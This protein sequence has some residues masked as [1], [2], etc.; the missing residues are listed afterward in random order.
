MSQQSQNGAD[1]CLGKGQLY[2]A[3]SNVIQ[4]LHSVNAPGNTESE[5]SRLEGASGQIPVLLYGISTF[6]CVLTFPLDVVL[7]C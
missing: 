1:L 3:L 6:V 2:S 7:L 5:E 4:T